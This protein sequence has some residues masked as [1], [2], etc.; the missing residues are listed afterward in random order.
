M[1]PHNRYNSNWE[2]SPAGANLTYS[3]VGLSAATGLQFF[4]K[5]MTVAI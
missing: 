3:Y 5:C 4:L 2:T 1:T